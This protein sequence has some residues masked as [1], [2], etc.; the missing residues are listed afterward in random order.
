MVDIISFSVA[1][2]SAPGASSSSA[3]DIRT[4][5]ATPPT[6]QQPQPQPQASNAQL[7]QA[8][9]TGFPG[10]QTAFG[11]AKPANRVPWHGKQPSSHR[12]QRSSSPDAPDAHGIWPVARSWCCR[13]YGCPSEC[14]TYR[15][16]WPVG[17][18]QCSF[19]RPAQH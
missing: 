9:M 6:I 8:Q 16:A 12:L 1:D 3:P 18:C 2:E 19:Y 11:S 13:W 7:L 5:T 10:Q 14:S 4:N 15:T 17:S